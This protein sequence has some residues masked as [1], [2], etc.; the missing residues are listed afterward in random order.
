M[1]DDFLES[2]RMAHLTNARPG[3]LGFFLLTIWLM[4]L[5]YSFADDNLAGLRKDAE[6]W[7]QLW[8]GNFSKPRCADMLISCCGG[9]PSATRLCVFY[10]GLIVSIFQSC[11]I[12]M[13]SFIRLHNKTSDRKLLK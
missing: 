9:K 7:I 5:C 12:F 13:H 6:G 2:D 3:A 4:W 8:S 11:S 10:N 1:D